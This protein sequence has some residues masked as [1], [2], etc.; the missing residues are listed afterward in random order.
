M[1][2]NSILVVSLWRLSCLLYL[3]LL[4]VLWA[5]V[6]DAAP[7][8]T[9]TSACQA[10]QV[11]ALVDLYAATGGSQWAVSAGWSSLTPT[12]PISTVCDLL[13]TN[14][15]GWCCDSSQSQCPA[16]Y[17]ISMLILARNNLKG[18]LPAS[19]FTALGPTLLSVILSSMLMSYRPLSLAA[20]SRHCSCV[21]GAG[22][23]LSGTLPPLVAPHLID[24]IVANNKL[25]GTVPN[26][27]YSLPH[28]YRVD[29]VIPSP[30]QAYC[31]DHH[32][33]FLQHCAS[34][35]REEIG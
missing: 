17:G 18:T 20:T 32:V 1:L 15:Q 3:C 5:P 34:C 14:Q 6:H 11:A 27:I 30:L 35:C 22:N 33:T 19:F 25:T 13:S 2:Q 9:C 16:E 23:Q 12:T 10:S 8:S 4:A 26:A 24:L 31:S 21:L 28:V 7:V 29:L